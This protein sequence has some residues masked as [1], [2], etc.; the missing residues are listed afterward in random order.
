MLL[1]CCDNL[2]DFYRRCGVEDRVKFYDRLYFVRPGGQ[3]DVLERGLLPHPLHLAGSFL[4]MGF[5]SLSDKISLIRILRSLQPGA[6]TGHFAD[7]TATFKDW[8]DAQGATRN[9][10]DRFWRPV[11]VSALNEEPEKASASAAAQVFRDGLLGDR[12]SYEMGVP[13]V[14]LSDLYSAALEHKLGAEVR[15][16]L[17]SNIRKIDPDDSDYDFQ[18][19]AV[20]FERVGSL[21]PELDLGLERFEHSP[22]TGVHLWFDRPITQLPHAVLLDRTMQWMFRKSDRYVQC[23]VSASRDLL[24]VSREDIVSLAKRDLASYFPAVAEARLERAHVIKEVRATYSIVPGLEAERPSSR[25]QHG[26][27][28]L[29]GDWTQTGWP[30]TMEGAVRSGYLAAQAA[31][32]LAGTP[33]NFLVG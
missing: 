31:A 12:T 9:S 15:I 33:T 6:S 2:L 21:L 26:N 32:E 5:L 16:R 29:A 10:Y 25:T 30:A 8:L 28:L 27:V 17:R 1:R 19:V 13:A 24:P 20:P 11:V 18:I 7:D 23:V 14:P 3:V 22:I 4:R